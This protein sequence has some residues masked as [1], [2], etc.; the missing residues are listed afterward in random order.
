MPL[1]S[2]SAQF[3]I[4]TKNST[5]INKTN[6]NKT[7]TKACKSLIQKILKKRWRSVQ[8]DFSQSKYFKVNI[9][10]LNFLKVNILNLL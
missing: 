8:D 5:T 4:S 6:T 1:L 9:L 3:D 10:N 7:N 2:G